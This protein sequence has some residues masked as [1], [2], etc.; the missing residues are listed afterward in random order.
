MEKLK[1]EIVVKI[2]NDSELESYNELTKHA[3]L[4]V[5]S[6]SDESSFKPIRDK[7]STILKAVSSSEVPVVLVANKVDEATLS[8]QV[9]EEDGKKAANELNFLDFFET[10]ATC[11]RNVQKAFTRLI[12]ECLKKNPEISDAAKKR[13]SKCTVM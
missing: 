3:I 10:A 1:Y 5:Y 9:Q 13:S 11:N 6:L 4:L 7:E 8:R 2:F 12:E